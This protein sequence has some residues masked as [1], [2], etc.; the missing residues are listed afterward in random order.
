MH[1][2]IL[3]AVIVLMLLLGIAGA[4]LAENFR[5]QHDPRLNA[6]AMKDV[7]ENPD[8]VYGFS[9]DPESTR[10]GE[11]AEYDWTDPVFVAQA[12]ETRQ[13]YHESLYTMY[14]ILYEMRDAGS[15]I[16]E[17]ARAV[18]A[19]RNRIRLASYADDPEG[20][21]R[22]KQSNLETYGSEDGP[23]A[24][25]LFEKYGSWETV[26]QKAFS[27]NPGMYA[28]CGLYDDYYTLYVELGLVSEEEE[29]KMT[30]K[31]EIQVN[32]H[33][34]TAELA[35]NSSAAA[36]IELLQAG[37]ITIDMQDYANFEKVGELPQ[38]LPTNDENI[39]TEACDLILYLGQRFVIY[40]DTNTWDFTRLGRITSVTGDE[41]KEIL[42]DGDVTAVLR[43]P[44]KNE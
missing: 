29:Q 7:V 30:Q 16:E 1:T 17:M 23:S 13:A 14:D 22:V 11:F 40:Y 9:P 43:L 34:L 12:M 15:S 20:L 39:T 10:L 6:E 8:A 2:K 31:I 44:V 36:L 5:Y 4:S 3:S 38:S 41:L 33:V 37:P 19:E 35:E 32:G 28:C 26:L 24:D 27:T 25:S 42:G 18:S 21:A